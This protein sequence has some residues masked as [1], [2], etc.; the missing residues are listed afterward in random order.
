MPMMLKMPYQPRAPA[1][2]PQW[3]FET[4]DFE[5]DAQ[6]QS[7]WMIYKAS[8]PPFYSFQTLLDMA[9]LRESL[10]V[11]YQSRFIEDFP[12][13]YFLMASRKP[14]VFKL[15]GDLATFAECIRQKDKDTLTRYAHACIDVISGLT[16]AFDLPIVTLS[17]VTGQALGGGLEAALALDFIMAEETA[18]L[19]VPEVAFNSFP[20][21]GAVSLLS[22]RLG[23]AKAES[24]I[25][26]G[27]VY[28]AKDMSDLGVVDYLAPAGLGIPSAMEWMAAGGE[29]RFQR[30]LALT[31]AR[32]R[33]FPLSDTELLDITNLWVACCTNVSDTDLRHMDRLVAAQ[34]RKAA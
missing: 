1:A 17:V 25:A 31:M 3:S 15:G 30:R 9:D 10:K 32:R 19:G 34:K 16:R 18:K 8:A 13:K 2:F 29:E 4:L 6:T 11:F 26:S 5:Y 22:R 14:G 23:T 33:F 27:R 12:L 20:G 7:A 24:L 28:S 21:M